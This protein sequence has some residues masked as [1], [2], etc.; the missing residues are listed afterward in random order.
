VGVGK[1]VT[2]GAIQMSKEL[3]QLVIE[4]VAKELFARM[5]QLELTHTK[6]LDQDVVFEYTR[7]THELYD[8]IR[9]NYAYGYSAVSREVST[10]EALVAFLRKDQS[11][12]ISMLYSDTALWSEETNTLVRYCHDYHHARHLLPDTTEGEKR[13]AIESFYSFRRHT[14]NNEALVLFLIDSLGQTLYYEH[15]D[16]QVDHQAEFT[17]EVWHELYLLQ[18][19]STSTN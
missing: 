1:Q 3:H 15:T 10:S 4:L 14:S 16:K 8:S 13:V 5:Q 2:Q 11:I 12:P 6:S 9:V 19:N 18:D 17:R 7:A